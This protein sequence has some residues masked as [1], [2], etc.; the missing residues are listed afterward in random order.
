[1]TSEEIPIVALQ[2]LA[3]L[4]AGHTDMRT[5]SQIPRRLEMPDTLGETDWNDLLDLSW[6]LSK[7]NRR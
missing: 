6:T 7:A 1:M 3:L 5:S 4:K 2:H